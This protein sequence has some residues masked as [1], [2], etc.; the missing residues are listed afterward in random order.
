[1][2]RAVA[3]E[4]DGGRVSSRHRTAERCSHGFASSARKAELVDRSSELAVCRRREARLRESPAADHLTGSAA[5]RERPMWR[6]V[7]MTGP[8]ILDIGREAI[9][10]LLKVSGPMMIVGLAVGLVISLFQ[11]LTQ[12]QE[13]T[14]AF[15]PKIVAI[16]VTLLL[17]LPFGGEQLSALM[18]TIA[19][20]IV[21]G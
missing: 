15:V 21:K 3:L 6:R 20:H 10:V 9:Y 19:D 13:M 1:M 12:I 4:K 8:E 11:A 16:F 7:S 17:T 18:Q 14:L 5:A 2:R